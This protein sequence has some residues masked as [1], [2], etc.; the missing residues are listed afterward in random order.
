MGETGEG[1]CPTDWQI[2]VSALPM[3]GEVHRLRFAPLGMTDG[4]DG[5]R[6]EIEGLEGSEQKHSTEAGGA[7]SGDEDR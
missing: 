5:R 3:Q 1:C 2:G 4:G 7:E 6:Y